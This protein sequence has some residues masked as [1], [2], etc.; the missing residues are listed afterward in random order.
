VTFTKYGPGSFRGDATVFSRGD[1]DDDD[2]DDDDDDAVSTMMEKD[3]SK[4]PFRH[5]DTKSPIVSMVLSDVGDATYVV[6]IRNFL[7]NVQLSAY[8]N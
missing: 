6:R 7:R 8:L 5:L 2:D 3:F 1:V 4:R